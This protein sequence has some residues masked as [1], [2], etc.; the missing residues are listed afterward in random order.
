M[1]ADAA[2]FYIPFIDVRDAADAHL[3]ALEKGRHGERYALNAETIK[4]VELTQTMDEE[5][6]P[7][8]YQIN[9]KELSYWLIWLVSFFN[10]D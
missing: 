9:T 8:G 2:Q 3:A 5:F 10:A 4:A 7:M 1:K 6:T